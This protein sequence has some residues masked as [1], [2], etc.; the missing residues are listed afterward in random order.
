MCVV[1]YVLFG[2]CCIGEILF[3][4]K[5]QELVLVPGTKQCRTV[6]I[7]LEIIGRNNYYQL[8]V[9]QVVLLGRLRQYTAQA[10]YIVNELATNQRQNGSYSVYKHRKINALRLALVVWLQYDNGRTAAL[11]ALTCLACRGYSRL[12]VPFWVYPSRN[13]HFSLQFS[14]R[15][16][17]ALP[18]SL[19]PGF[20]LPAPKTA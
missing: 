20:S 7:Y 4:V 6:S 12:Y 3:H 8:H 19:P 15:R 9:C 14:P 16:F 11:E 1:Y 10:A 2:V 5:H 17:F 13:V 18:Y